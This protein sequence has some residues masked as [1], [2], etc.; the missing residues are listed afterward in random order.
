M[1]AVRPGDLSIELLLGLL[2]PQP[3]FADQP[4]DHADGE[5]ATA[6]PEGK[7]VVAQVGAV[8][9]LAIFRFGGGGFESQ[10]V[11][12]RAIVAAGKLV[13]V[14]HIPFQAEAEGAAENRERLEG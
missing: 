4:V 5:G 13:D 6:E 10:I 3:L 2:T 14:Q 1:G 12:M 11:K 8:F 9:L 7:D